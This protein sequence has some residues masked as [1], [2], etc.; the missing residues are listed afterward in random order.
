MGIGYG[1]QVAGATGLVIGVKT[2]DNATA[3]TNMINRE[4]AGCPA[5]LLTEGV[6]INPGHEA[7]RDVLDAIARSN[8]RLGLRR[9]KPRKEDMQ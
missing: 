3:L 4:Y 7:M 6:F 8:P 5:S 1:V 9:V 2:L